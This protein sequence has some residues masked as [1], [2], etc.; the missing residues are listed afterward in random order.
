MTKSEKE[1]YRNK[2]DISKF[3]F[4]NGDGIGIK[5]IKSDINDYIVYEDNMRKI[6]RVKAHQQFNGRSW[7]AWGDV[8]IYLD[9]CIGV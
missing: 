1:K 8:R 2:P 7:F 9:E 5:E 3:S 4:C 6:H